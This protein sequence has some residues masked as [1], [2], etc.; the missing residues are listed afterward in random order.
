MRQLLLHRCRM[1][2]MRTRIKNQL[3]GMAKN[4]G[5][6]SPRVWS[7]RRREQIEGLPL[8]AGVRSGAGIWWLCW[9]I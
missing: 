6:L 2:R 5:W 1:V 4:E 7:P 9:R 8:T 3:D